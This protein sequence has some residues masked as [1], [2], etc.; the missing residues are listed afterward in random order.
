MGKDIIMELRNYR[1]NQDG[2]IDCEVLINDIW[3]PF[4]ARENDIMEHGRLIFKE[5]KGKAKPYEG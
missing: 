3:L 5:L 2:S 4:T 1:Y